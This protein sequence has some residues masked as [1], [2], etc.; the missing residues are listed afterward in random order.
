MDFPSRIQPLGYPQGCPSSWE[1]ELF[2]G[3]RGLRPGWVEGV[4]ENLPGPNGPNTVPTVPGSCRCF[5]VPQMGVS[6]IPKLRL[7]MVNG[8]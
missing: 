8:G 2:E 7:I 3:A 4:D 5:P 6:Q 1:S